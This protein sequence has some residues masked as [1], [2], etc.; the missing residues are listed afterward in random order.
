VLVFPRAAT[1]TIRY[2]VHARNLPNPKRGEL[3][4]TTTAKAPPVAD[5][6]GY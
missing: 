6:N 1:W 5:A 4:I 2:E 3:T